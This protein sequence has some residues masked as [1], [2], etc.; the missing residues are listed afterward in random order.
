M[1]PKIEIFEK[2]DGFYAGRQLKSGEMAKGNY[3]IT[4]Y[5]IMTM[6][7][8]LFENYV[9]QTGEPKMFMRDSDGNVFVTVK[10]PVRQDN[11]DAPEA[12]E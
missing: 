2:K 6:F 10:V 4:D 11:G 7:T 5:D 8:T 12:E 3:R 1:T 9:A